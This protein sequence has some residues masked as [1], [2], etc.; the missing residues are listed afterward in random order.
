MEDNEYAHEDYGSS[1]L[2]SP[3]TPKSANLREV[4]ARTAKSSA[5]INIF[6]PIQEEEA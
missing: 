3:R 1:S 5:L 2:R 6:D 4:N